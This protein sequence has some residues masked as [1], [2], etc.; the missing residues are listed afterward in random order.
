MRDEEPSD[1]A[2]L[3]TIASW[4]ALADDEPD[5]VELLLLFGGSLPTAW[6]RVAERVR[7]GQ[8]GRLMVVGGRGHTT[9]VLEQVVGAAPGGTEADL[10]AAY[11]RTEHGIDDVLLER[12]STNCGSNVVLA[13]RVAEAHGL[14]PRTVALVQE[15]TMQRRMD[16]VFRQV[17]AGATAVNLPGPDARHLWGSERWTSL[18][19]GEVPRLRDVEDGYGPRGRGFLAHVDVPGE[20][21]SAHATLLARHPA[22]GREANR[23]RSD[24]QDE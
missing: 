22:W 11:L 4:L 13:R 7:A 3:D 17:W 14:R 24:I 6:D 21:S 12:E 18:V 2:L 10:V 1:L 5:E 23:G 8:V 19:M 9:D 16:A 20:V 15:Q